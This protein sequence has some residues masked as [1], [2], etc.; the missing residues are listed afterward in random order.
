MPESAKKKKEDAKRRK[1]EEAKKNEM[2]TFRFHDF[3]NKFELKS[4]IT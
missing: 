4:D 3:R 1:E 2:V